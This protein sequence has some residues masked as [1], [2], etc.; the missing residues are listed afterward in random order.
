MPDHGLVPVERIERAILVIRGH[1]VMLDADLALLYEVEVKV[2]NQ[3]VKRNIDR[4]PADFMFQLSV[5]EADFLRCHS[6]T[7]KTD[8]TEALRSQFVTSKGRGGRRYLPYAFTEQGVAMLSSVLRSPR[9]VQVNIE[10]MR[11]FVRLRQMLQTNAD[12]AR[13]LA[14]LERKYNAQFKA[15]F[16]AIRDLMTPPE[17]PKRKIG[18]SKREPSGE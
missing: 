3:A 14:V 15:V 8:D 16:D 1:K 7:L 5:E 13:K 18:F 9:A 11:A 10:I 2:L 6:G 12:L 17:K 4:F